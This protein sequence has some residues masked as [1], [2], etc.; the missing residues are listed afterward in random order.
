MKRKIANLIK[1]LIHH[2]E[3]DHTLFAILDNNHPMDEAIKIFKEIRG[4][5]RNDDI[6]KEM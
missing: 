4:I 1:Y 6:K 3:D 2:P 5:N